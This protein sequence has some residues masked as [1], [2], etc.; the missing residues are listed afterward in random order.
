MDM[1]FQSGSEERR[2][3]LQPA[4]AE[5]AVRRE[6][7]GEALRAVRGRSLNGDLAIISPTISSDAIMSFNKPLR[8]TPLARYLLKRKRGVLKSLLV[9]F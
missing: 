7:R 5:A 4:A 9:K 8:F 2:Q 3:P 6:D 1:R